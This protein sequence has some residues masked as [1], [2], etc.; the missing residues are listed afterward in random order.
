MCGSSGILMFILP[1][2]MAFGYRF[3]VSAGI[4]LACYFLGLFLGKTSKK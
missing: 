3:F 4:P 1:E 2:Q